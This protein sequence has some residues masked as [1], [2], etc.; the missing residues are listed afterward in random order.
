[1]PTDISKMIQEM[2]K[3]EWIDLSRIAYRQ[4]L[5]KIAQSGVSDSMIRYLLD[6]FIEE[7]GERDITLVIDETYAEDLQE[8][9]HKYKAEG[10]LPK[11]FPPL[12]TRR[13]SC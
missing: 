4:I 11:H 5:N 7:L 12:S 10:V 9:L 8:S 2:K 6:K 13:F 3:D 1:M